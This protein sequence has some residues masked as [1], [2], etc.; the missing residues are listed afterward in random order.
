M[1]KLS[2][3]LLHIYYESRIEHRGKMIY[4]SDSRNNNNGDF[5]ILIEIN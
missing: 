3:F 4:Y 5:I 2:L 1:R